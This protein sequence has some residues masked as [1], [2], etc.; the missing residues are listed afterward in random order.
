M[1]LF[2][3]S[4]GNGGV[5]RRGRER[6]G[7][8][9]PCSLKATLLNW[10]RDWTFGLGQDVDGAEAVQRHQG[11][12]VSESDGRPDLPAEN[13]P[14]T[15]LFTSSFILCNPESEIHGLSN[16]IQLDSHS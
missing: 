10:S 13:T 15:A 9:K 1:T 4:D 2:G 14:P 3:A 11:N 6:Q 5:R 12:I 8:N 16:V 7:E